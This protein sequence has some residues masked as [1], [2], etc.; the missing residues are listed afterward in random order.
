[1]LVKSMVWMFGVVLGVIAVVSADRYV[2]LV[3]GT[4]IVDFIPWDQNGALQRQHQAMVG[5]VAIISALGCLASVMVAFNRRA[6]QGRPRRLG[7][8]LPRP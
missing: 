8:R 2:A 4:L 5:R 6:K 7:Y 1:M 3:S